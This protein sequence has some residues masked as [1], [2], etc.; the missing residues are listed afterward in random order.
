[1]DNFGIF[2]EVGLGMD[3]KHTPPNP[4]GKLEKK[5][6]QADEFME[7]NIPFTKAELKRKYKQ[8]AKKY[9]PDTA[10]TDEKEAAKKELKMDVLLE[11]NMAGEESKHGFSETDVYEAVTEIS[12]MPHLRLRGLMTVAPYTENAEENRIYFRKMKELLVDINTKNIDNISM[13]CLS[14]GM[15]SDYEVAIE[16]G[17]TLVRI[18]TGLFGQRD[19]NKGDNIV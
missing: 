14:M 17:A 7:L 15:S 6:I 9:H 19:Y 3:G 4:H 13:D 1:M 5:Y 8:L 16:E 12:Q 2:E 11:I 18:G 10:G